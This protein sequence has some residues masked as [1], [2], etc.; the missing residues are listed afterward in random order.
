M[1]LCGPDTIV[2]H[3]V[4]QRGDFTVAIAC[5]PCGPRRSLI[6]A[7]EWGF[8]GC[9]KLSAAEKVKPDCCHT[10]VVVSIFDRLRCLGH[11][12]VLP[13]HRSI[14]LI[15]QQI[16][17]YCCSVSVV[18]LFF[19]VFVVFFVFFFFFF[20]FSFTNL[21][22][23]ISLSNTHTKHMH[24]HSLYVSLSLN[25]CNFENQKTTV[26]KNVSHKKHDI[27]R[28]HGTAS[29]VSATHKWCRSIQV[30]CWAV[31]MWLWGNCKA[32][33]LTQNESAVVQI[34]LPVTQS[35]E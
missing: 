12:L 3:F 28:Q 35:D 2:S 34:S 21:Y 33:S 19:S 22:K 1:Y 8:C 20:S 25:W 6:Y 13:H 15:K 29:T 18:F 9:W 31:H 14:T 26:P 24:I 11:C 17:L 7:C 10:P 27:R 4:V 23:I 16:Q 30:S 5:V 32:N